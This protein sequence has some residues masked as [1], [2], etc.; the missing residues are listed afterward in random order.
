MGARSARLWQHNPQN[1]AR[2]TPHFTQLYDSLYDSDAFISLSPSA[3]R[4]YI[5][6]IRQYKGGANDEFELPYSV[7]HDKYKLFGSSNTFKSAKK[8]L[9]AAGF[10]EETFNGQSTMNANRYRFSAAWYTKHIEKSR[11]VFEEEQARLKA[12]AKEQLKK[13]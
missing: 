6:M 12:D 8:E 4:L 2:N 13:M 10:I 11:A 3:Q 9:I 7:W 5:C 1:D